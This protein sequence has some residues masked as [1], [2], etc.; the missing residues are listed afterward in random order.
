[1]TDF[2]TMNPSPEVPETQVTIGTDPVVLPNVVIIGRPNVGK[3]T[4]FNKLTG[5]RAAIVGDE[6]GITR[7]RHFGTVEWQNHHFELVDTGG[8]VPDDEALIP[9]NIFRQA[10]IAIENTDLILWMVDA[11]AGIT[12]LDQE[13]ARLLRETGKTVYVVANKAETP[14]V[15][16]AAQEFYQFGFPGFFPVSSEHGAGVG[17]LLD[18]IVEFTKAPY[19]PD[20]KPSTE[21][22]VAI[23]GRPNVGKSSLVNCLL[24]E[25]RVIV[26]PIAGTTRDSIDS[27]LEHDGKTFRLIDTAGIRRKGKTTEMA[28]KLSVIMARKALERA[29]IAIILIDAVEGPT[30][31]DA[32]IA[33]YIQEAG[34]SVIIALNKWDLIEKDSTTLALYEGQLRER[35]KFLDYAPVIFTSAKT[36]QRVPKLLDA[37]IHAYQARYNRIGT[38]QLNRFF[39][40]NLDNPRAT[41]PANRPVKVQFITQARGCPPTF[42]LF[43]NTTNKDLHFSYERYV[44][45]RL[46]EAFDFFAAPIRI[47]HRFKAPKTK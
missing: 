16:L 32:T 47:V 5:T 3:S 4:L 26:S 34:T 6:P 9:V 43:T 23:V 20:P 28:E 14:K 7:D 37:A 2:D 12:P 42:V 46:R 21:I 45:N 31:L 30:A 18:E 25:E 36:G 15:A 41:T 8:I 11:R 38:S 24:G 40:E 39:S 19:E 17:E 13:I 27:L 44:I 10:Q 33:G 1:M 22:R 29:D 35:L